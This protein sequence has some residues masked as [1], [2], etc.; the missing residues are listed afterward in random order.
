MFIFLN[1]LR[2]IGQINGHWIEGGYPSALLYPESVVLESSTKPSQRCFLSTPDW[3]GRILKNP[4]LL[5][6]VLCTHFNEEGELQT[7]G[8]ISIT[9]VDLGK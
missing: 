4:R 9:L 8:D 7:A 2:K 3:V 6:R 1:C 5:I